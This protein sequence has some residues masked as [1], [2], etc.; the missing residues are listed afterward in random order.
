MSNKNLLQKN[1]FI[2]IEFIGKI[3]E[4]EI[5]DSNLKEALEKINPNYNE[6]QTKPFIFS[7]G[8]DM[9]LKGVEDYLL[10]EGQPGKSYNIELNPEDAFG[11]RNSKL[12]QLIP[13]NVFIQQK[14]N[15][16][17]GMMFNFDGRIGKIIS[18]SGGRVIVDFNH[19]LAGKKVIYDLK[20]LRKVEDI[21]EKTKSF[22]DFIFK[23]DFVFEI[24][25]QDLFIKAEKQMKQFIELFKDK[26]K[27]VLNLNLQVELI[28]EDLSETLKKA[29]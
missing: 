10:K 5:F 15:P 18:V 27:E 4:G 24:K 23:K 29:Q 8:N 20:V 11:I 3:K 14:I 9:F 7:L 17:Q 28:P 13:L 21:N 16:S 25:N 6:N 12:V 19:P 1:D 26:F 22:I 2:E